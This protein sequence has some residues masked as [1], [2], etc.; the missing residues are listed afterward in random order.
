LA[1]WSI[2]PHSKCGWEQFLTGS[3]PVPSAKLKIRIRKNRPRELFLNKFFIF[4]KVIPVKF[5]YYLYRYRYTMKSKELPTIAKNIKTYKKKKGKYH[6][7]ILWI[8]I[9]LG[10]SVAIFGMVKLASYSS[11]NNILA[12]PLAYSITEN[13]WIKGNKESSIILIEYSD[14]QCPA[15]ATYHPFVKQLSQEF[16]S[17][18][19]FV[20]RHFPLRNIHPNAELAGQATEAAGQQS[21]FWEM[22]DIIFE[23]QRTW[24]VQKHSQ[25]KE[26]FITYAKQLNLDVEQFKIDIVSKKVEDK[27]NNDYQGGFLSGV[28]STP[29]FFLNGEKIQNPRNYEEFRNI[30]KQAIV[31][32]P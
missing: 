5:I 7:I 24:S 17:E 2:A 19:L 29:T 22:H 14:F 21:K 4:D 27:V 10:I 28:N 8:L 12:V 6:H 31:N 26:T 1:E 9:F 13:D 15:C 20:Y 11:S 23:N 32:N 30:I 3:N 16:E 25:A 18:L